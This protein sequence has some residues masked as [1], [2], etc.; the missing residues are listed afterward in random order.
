MIV[1]GEAKS[2]PQVYY[3]VIIGVCFVLVLSFHRFYLW[4][5]VIS[6]LSRGAAGE[7]DLQPGSCIL[8]KVLL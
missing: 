1:L 5:F 7:K 8:T 2:E 4:K 3:I 6:Y